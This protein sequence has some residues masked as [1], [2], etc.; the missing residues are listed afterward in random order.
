M[1]WSSDC[2]NKKAYIGLIGAAV[3]LRKRVDSS[4]GPEVFAGFSLAR[5]LSTFVRDMLTAAMVWWGEGP[6][7]GMLWGSSLVMAELNC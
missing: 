3:S 4:S 5:S 1:P 2:C 6:R 7:S